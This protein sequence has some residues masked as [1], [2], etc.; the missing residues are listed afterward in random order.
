[1]DM[2]TNAVQ[3]NCEFIFTTNNDTC[4][5]CVVIID[6]EGGLFEGES[7]VVMPANPSS[8]CNVCIRPKKNI[9]STM[10]IQVRGADRGC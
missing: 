9:S 6:L 7:H 5:T 4:I 10:K 8:T 1:M 2:A 3:R